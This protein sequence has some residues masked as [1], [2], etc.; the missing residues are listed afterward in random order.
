MPEPAPE[1]T[2]SAV[3]VRVWDLPT[4]LFHWA[5]AI[6]L[7]GSIVSVNIGGL[8][9]NWHFRFGYAIATLLLF[10]LVWGFVGGHWSRFASFFYGPGAVWRYLR[11]AQPPHRHGWDT[12]HSPLGA[13]SVYA[14][15]IVLAM[16]V[17]SGLFTDDEIAFAGPLTRL[18]SSELVTELSR[19]H[20]GVG[21]P[22]VI[23]L[24][25]LHLLAVA[26]YAVVRRRTLVRPMVTGDK[27]L[28]V[29]APASRDDWRSRLL[30]AAV[31]AMCALVVAWAVSPAA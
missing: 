17:G 8:A 5:L 22:L 26:F 24:V 25:A 19:Y 15:L 1:G 30:A 13:L 12:G 18:A 21:K 6:C 14:L 2:T 23:A 10:R 27:H 16:Q 11:G 28:P 20:K 7:V 3:V 29:A 9:M 31:L 4:R